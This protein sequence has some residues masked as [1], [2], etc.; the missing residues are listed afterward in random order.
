M[1]ACGAVATSGFMGPGRGVE[2]H[3]FRERLGEST[4]AISM[5]HILNLFRRGCSTV[6]LKWLISIIVKSVSPSRCG[7]V[8]SLETKTAKRGWEDAK[9]LLALTIRTMPSLW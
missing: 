5:Q 4:C 9:D 8:E 6:L 3:N 2:S 7:S 1:Q